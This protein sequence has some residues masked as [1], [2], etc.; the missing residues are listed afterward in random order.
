MVN[1]VKILAINIKS[2]SFPQ[3]HSKAQSQLFIE[4]TMQKQQIILNYS[5]IMNK[6][7]ASK[8]K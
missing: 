5:K 2:L 8:N 6:L 4:E 3:F 7:V 1:R